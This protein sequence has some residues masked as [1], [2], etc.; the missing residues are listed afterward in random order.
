MAKRTLC[1]EL[2]SEDV[3]H[4]FRHAPDD[5]GVD[6]PFPRTFPEM[7]T[8]GT[9]LIPMGFR[10]VMLENGHPAPYRIVPRSSIYKSALRMANSEGI[11]DSGYRGEIYVPVD[12]VSRTTYG[13]SVNNTW[14][15]KGRDLGTTNVLAGERFF[16]I[17]SRDLGPIHEV[18][19]VE[20]LPFDQTERGA[21]GFGSTGKN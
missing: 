10:A 14:E 6:I 16:Q 1:I 15:E 3:Q 13:W 2:L 19:F 11:I 12:I 18:K 4:H 5:A 7:I 21:G 17:V 20:K 9:Y 8:G